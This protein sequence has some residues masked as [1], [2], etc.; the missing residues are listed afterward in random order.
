MSRTFK[1]TSGDVD[2]DVRGQPAFT[3]SSKEKIA[4]DISECTLVPT[5]DIGFG[6]GIVEL[7]GGVQDPSNVP[8]LIQSRIVNGI[9]RLKDL[10]SRNQRLIR[11]DGELVAAL[12][13]VSAG[14]N[15]PGSRTDFRFSF[16]VNTVSGDKIARRGIL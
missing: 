4:Q 8:N 15:S 12:V 10:Q 14:P 11:D 7:V 6:M 3:L 13:S 9:Q 2:Y 5:D 16:A 1:I